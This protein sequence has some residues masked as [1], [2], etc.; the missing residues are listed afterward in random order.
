MR[1]NWQSDLKQMH[2]P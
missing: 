1:G 2:T